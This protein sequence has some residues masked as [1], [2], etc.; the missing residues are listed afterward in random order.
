MKESFDGKEFIVNPDEEVKDVFYPF[1]Q[2]IIFPKEKT[3]SEMRFV[4]AISDGLK[5]KHE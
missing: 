3:I 4:D 2:K 5:T 1:E